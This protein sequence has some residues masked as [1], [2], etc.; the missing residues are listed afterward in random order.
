[1]DQERKDRASGARKVGAHL[2]LVDY[3]P[4]VVFANMFT[5]VWDW[6]HQLISSRYNFL[7]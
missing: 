7:S 6:F 1:M 4:I 5:S 2:P 3:W